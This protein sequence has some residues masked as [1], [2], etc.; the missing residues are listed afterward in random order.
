VI[1]NPNDLLDGV[2]MAGQRIRRIQLRRRTLHLIR[3]K[4]PEVALDLGHCLHQL[5]RLLGCLKLHVLVV[6]DQLAHVGLKLFG[7]IEALDALLAGLADSARTLGFGEL[8]RVLQVLVVLRVESDLID[9]HGDARSAAHEAAIDSG[10]GKDGGFTAVATLLVEEVGN[11]G[12]RH[13]LLVAQRLDEGVF[14]VALDL[15]LATA[16]LFKR[17]QHGDVVLDPGFDGAGARESIHAY[18]LAHEALRA[19]KRRCALDHERFCGFEK[20]LVFSD[21]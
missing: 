13:V 15:M 4:D 5:L 7:V 1:L 2:V 9:R 17:L 3:N 11:V 14:W 18:E 10:V 21:E 12:P 8:R 20:L 19:V 6:L 16:A